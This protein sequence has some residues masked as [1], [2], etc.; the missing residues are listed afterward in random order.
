MKRL[1]W[2]L[3][4]VGLIAGIYFVVKNYFPSVVSNFIP[5]NKEVKQF[6]PLDNETPSPFKI[7]SDYKMDVYADLKNDL[8]RVIEF[9]DS[10]NMIVSL[11]SKGK[12]AVLTDR[13][14]DLR[15]ES[16]TDILVGLNKPHGIALNGNYLYVAE[17]GGVFRYLYNSR[18]LTVGEK[19]LLFTLPED[20]R[21]FTRTI[22]IHDNKLYTSVG[23]SCD[24]CVEENN[25]R[26]SIL[27]SELDGSSL[28]VFAKGLRNTVFFDFD[29]QG[30]MWG[31]DMGRDMLGDNLPPDE[32]NIIEDGKDYGWPYCYGSQIKD[33]KFNSDKS[34]T[35]EATEPP[36]YELPA[37][38]APLGFMFDGFGSLFVALHGS[39]NSKVPV[40]Y[41]VVKLSTFAGG[42]SGSQDFISG[43]IQG[44]DKIL[45]R[46]AGLTQDK[47]GNIYVSDD[48]T[49][50]IYVLVK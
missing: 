16:K 33:T 27:V 11:T 2:I 3:F 1:F 25:F 45:G 17:S 36:I 21:H 6:F 32:I 30:K 14:L 7:P 12:I 35:C 22:R 10:G 20:G 47:K 41:K 24:V 19:E 15:S 26:S 39:W 38:S 5:V 40:G 48:K 23:S 31:A 18:D 44:K 37:H 4:I 28:R 34:I 49:G 46:P 9:D 42:V 43:F 29:S 8:P 50:L 13:D